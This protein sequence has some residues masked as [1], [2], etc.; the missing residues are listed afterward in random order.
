METLKKMGP[1]KVSRELGIPKTTLYYWKKGKYKPPLA[2]WIP[3]PSNELA[4]VLGVLNGDGYLHANRHHYYRIQLGVKDL[5]F[6]EAFSIAM[7]K[8][9]NKKYL[10]PKWDKSNNIW[11]VVYTSKAFYIWYKHQNLDT[12]K[13]YIEYSRDAV[14]NFLRGLYDSDGNHYIYKKRYSQIRLYNNNT[15][16][17]KYV[18]HLLEKYFDI[19]TKGPYVG[20]R[21]GTENKMGNGKIVRRNHDTYQMV[22]D[23]IQYAQRFLDEIGFSIT[24]KQLGLSRRK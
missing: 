23:R 24:E 9:L 17:L 18:Q 22:I 4:Y 7:A 12:L 15:E 13:P 19:V 20:T 2:R 5:K 1:T 10:V 6:A 8:T 16:L 21:A 14:A 11:V 3:K